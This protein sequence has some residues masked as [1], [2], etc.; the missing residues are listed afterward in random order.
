MQPFNVSFVLEFKAGST[1]IEPAKMR[2]RPRGRRLE[3][4]FAKF[5]RLDLLIEYEDV[6]REPR[7]RLDP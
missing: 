7:L 3:V 2:A 6:F 1:S 4:L 5:I